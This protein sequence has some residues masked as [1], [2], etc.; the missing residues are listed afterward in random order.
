MKK[1]ERNSFLYLSITIS[2]QKLF[3]PFDTSKYFN[4][5]SPLEFK[6]KHPY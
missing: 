2:M 1:L 3:N 5:F 6:A 4:Q